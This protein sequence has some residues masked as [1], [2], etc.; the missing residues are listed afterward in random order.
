MTPDELLVRFKPQLL[1]DSQEAFFADS[2]EQMT[3]NPGNQLRRA[4]GQVVAEGAELTL[5][6]L[7]AARYAN[8]VDVEADDMLGIQGT[9]YRTQYA[10]LREARPDLRNRIYGHAR[11][12]GE[13]RLWLQYWFWYFYND[14]HLAADFGLHEGDWEMVQI[15]MQGDD[16]DIAVYAQHAYAEMRAW[17]DV[18]KTADGRPRVYPGRGSH[19]SYYEPGL[20]DT[21]GWFDI[22]DGKR[23]TPDLALEVIGDGAPPWALWPGFW[24]DTKAH[25]F[26]DDQSPR[27]PSQ[28]DQWGDPATLLDK[29]IARPRREPAE[30]PE[31]RVRR[32]HGTLRLDFDF[33]GRSGDGEPLRLVAT[34]NSEDEPGVPPKTFTFDVEGVQRGHFSTRFPLART[35][36]YDVYTSITVRRDGKDVPSASRC[37]P[38]APGLKSAIPEWLKRPIWWLER[39]FVRR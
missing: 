26:L 10:R 13:G 31:V 37:T 9:D 8:G 14:Y 12:D 25:F 30:A 27:G 32:Q 17:A 19:A 22:A 34:V 5:A 6:L 28:H 33:T 20:Y 39:L 3:A 38:I 15:R 29:A 35:H 4:G 18:E 7:A 2:A 24:G 16:P 11:A 23:E 1:Y 36:R 21:E